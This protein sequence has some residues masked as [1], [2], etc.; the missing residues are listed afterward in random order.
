[1]KTKKEI[2]ALVLFILVCFGVAGF[3]SLF[4]A[5]TIET[6]YA[7]LRKPAW[8]PPARVFGPVWTF[9]YSCIAIS[10]WLVWKRKDKENARLVL[11]FYIMQ[12]VLNA[13]WT[14]LFFG[15]HLAL[16]AFAEILLLWIY[17]GLYILHSWRVSRPASLLFIPYFLWVGFASYLNLFLWWLNK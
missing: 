4:T 6:W 10:G 11:F 1:M 5:S 17:I 9:L 3:G 7:V 2:L 16:V 14:P 15:L 13:L 8:N 12:L